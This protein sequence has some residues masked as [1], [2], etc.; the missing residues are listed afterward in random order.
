MVPAAAL[1]LAIGFQEVARNLGS[2]LSSPWLQA[3]GAIFG[4]SPIPQFTAIAVLS[5]IV[6]V[7]SFI[8]AAKDNKKFKDVD[9]AKQ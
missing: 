9:V 5:A 2:F 7:V 8:V 4:D 6:T 1:T 3:T